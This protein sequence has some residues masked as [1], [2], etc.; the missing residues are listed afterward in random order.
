[1]RFPDKRLLGALA[2]SL[3]AHFG[4]LASVPSLAPQPPPSYRVLE[5]RLE[6]AQQPPPPVA[7]PQP[8][9][10]PRPQVRPELPPVPMDVPVGAGQ[11]AEPALLPEAPQWDAVLPVEEEPAPTSAVSEAL[12]ATLPAEPEPQQAV[13]SPPALPARAE[14]RYTLFKGGDGLNVGD[15]VQIWQSDGKYYTL[16]ST[17]EASGLFTL[18]MPGKHEQVSQGKIV[19][20]GLQP[21]SY[22]LQRGSAEKRDE[23]RFDWAAQT[24]HMTS[25]GQQ[26]TVP[27]APGTLDL[28]SFSWQFAFSLPESGE[29]PVVLTNG[30]KLSHYRYTLLA[31]EVLDT[32]L[33]KLKTVHLSKLRQPGEEGTEIWLGMDYH[34]LPVKIRQ[35]D[36]KGDTAEQV[37]TEIRYE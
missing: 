29:V 24:L 13:E 6:Q 33:G 36:K 23:A 9:P 19:M 3:V 11:V 16:T 37:I 17:A 4:L 15:V 22:S 28:L 7:L 20:G 12:P 32:P 27:L 5:A 1:M 34:Y 10:R 8:K 31:E 14:L 21:E 35:I 18:F 26:S 30:R 25:R 2:V